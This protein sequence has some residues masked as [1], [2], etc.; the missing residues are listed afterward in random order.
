ML[1][2]RLRP[3]VSP[4]VGVLQVTA[5]LG[6]DKKGKRGCCVA[7]PCGTA[8]PFVREYFLDSDDGCSSLS[9]AQ[10][11]YSTCL[12]CLSIISG[13]AVAKFEGRSGLALQLDERCVL[14]T[15]TDIVP[16]T[17]LLLFFALASD[18][19]EN[20]YLHLELRLNVSLRSKFVV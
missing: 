18:S 16:S 6:V 8:G 5:C 10:T 4:H 9:M 15:G 13:L 11:M 19:A 17:P 14:V 2:L 20:T 7:T 3:L 12:V 1:H